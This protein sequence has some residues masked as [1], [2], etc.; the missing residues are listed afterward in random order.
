MVR[1]LT[2]R[3]TPSTPKASLVMRGSTPC[4]SSSVSFSSADAA[5]GGERHDAAGDVMGFAERHA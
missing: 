4:I 3:S 5:L 2:D 1:L